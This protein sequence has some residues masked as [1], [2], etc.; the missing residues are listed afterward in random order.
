MPDITLTDSP[1]ASSSSAVPDFLDP[2]FYVD[3]DAMH[4]ALR[5][6]RQHHPVAWDEK[7]RLWGVTRHADVVEVEPGTTSSSAVR[8]T[9]RSS[10]P[11]RT[12]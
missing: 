11:V 12:T 2:G 5:Q 4:E 9:G 8:G 1:T 7:N 6:L 10:P 3:I